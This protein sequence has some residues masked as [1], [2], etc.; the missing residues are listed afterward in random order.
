VAFWPCGV[1]FRHVD[2]P[3]RRGAAGGHGRPRAA[4]R[5]KA[6]ELATAGATTVR[7]QFYG[8]LLGHVVML[9]PE[10]NEFCVA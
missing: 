2:P 3:R 7:E 10:G 5:A 6:A 8:E 4:Q 9:D 1:R